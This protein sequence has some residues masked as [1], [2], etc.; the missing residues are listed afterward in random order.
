VPLRRWYRRPAALVAAAIAAVVIGGGAVVAINQV[1]DQDQQV[2][3]PAECVAQA[4]DKQELSPDLGAGSAIYAPSCAAVTV[5]VTGLP[6][7]PTDRTY[8]LW[9]I[10]GEAPPRSLGV[11][12]KAATGE[13]E[14]LTT[15][16]NA[17]ENVLA[18]TTEPAGG[19]TAPTLP[20]IWKTTLG[21]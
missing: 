6:D 13:P 10:A 11:L 8:Q 14:L 12:S 1:N 3:S 15:T 5:D 17:G 19:S 7:L 2:A 16:T 9:A 20:I 18:I 21:T 4:A